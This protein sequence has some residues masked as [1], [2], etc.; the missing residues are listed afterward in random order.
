M[1]CLRPA[2]K[3]KN[4]SCLWTTELLFPQKRCL[5]NL[6]RKNS[7]RMSLQSFHWLKVALNLL[8][9]TGR[10]QTFFSTHS[11]ENGGS[12]VAWRGSSNIL[13]GQGLM[14]RVQ[15][16]RQQPHGEGCGHESLPADGGSSNCKLPLKVPESFLYNTFNHLTYIWLYPSF[17]GS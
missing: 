16:V 4:S 13:P 5:H 1:F 8:D 14:T 9:S 6:E 11:N 3:E 15:F 7:M 12:V 17:L 10:H 2:L